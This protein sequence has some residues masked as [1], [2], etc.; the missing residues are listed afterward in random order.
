VKIP[1]VAFFFTTLRSEDMSGGGQYRLLEAL[2]FYSLILNRYIKIPAGYICDSYTVPRFFAWLVYNAD[3]RPAF[4]H[5]WLCDG[6]EPG[7]SRKTA[8]RIILEAMEAA[9]LSWLQR[10]LIY[11]GTRVGDYLGI[12]GRGDEENFYSDA[13]V[14]VGGMRPESRTDEGA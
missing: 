14:D 2:V 5:D 13:G 6:H 1:E 10:R 4:L 7:V 11:R 12:G 3:R 9:G 8:D